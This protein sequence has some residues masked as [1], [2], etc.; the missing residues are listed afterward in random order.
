VGKELIKTEQVTRN[1]YLEYSFKTV[2]TGN[3]A[4][5]PDAG[6]TDIA[7]IDTVADLDIYMQYKVTVEIV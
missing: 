1:T 5:T 7:L 4:P 6:F 3:P 2:Q